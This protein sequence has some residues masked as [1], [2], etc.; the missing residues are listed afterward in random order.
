MRQADPSH[1]WCV[2]H[3][4]TR[5]DLGGAQLATLFEVEH[6]TFGSAPRY[7]LSGAGGLLDGETNQLSNVEHIVVSNLV[8]EIN[9]RRDLK[10]IFEI[11]GILRG[12]HKG[13]HLLVH[14]HSSKAGILGR[15]AAFFA[16][17]DL[18]VHSIHGFGHP[19]HGSKITRA[20][21][22]LAEYLT[23]RITDGFTADSLANIQ[24]AK[25]EHLL[26]RAPS[27][28][29]YC[30]IDVDAFTR[31]QH[32]RDTTL[33]SL[34]V[35]VDSQVVINI[36]CLKPQKNPVAYLQIAFLLNKSHPK[37]KFLLVGD[38]ELRSEL[39]D[40]IADMGLEETV[41]MLGWRR[42]ISDLL[43][44]SD[45]FVLTS[46][47]E[48]LPQ[49][50]F[51]AMAAGLPLVATAV[52]GTPEAITSGYNGYLFAPEDTVGMASAINLLLSDPEQRHKMGRHGLTQVDK[53]S[54]KNMLAKLEAFYAR[55]KK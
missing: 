53:F 6:S 18:I 2:V 9:L 3:I 48:G 35:P 39:E 37:A 10:A 44:A 45:V 21:M 23:A 55:L 20:F 22:W 7:L 8:R 41:L 14:T 31:P 36:S 24:Q 25:R 42:D 54:Q 26:G 27:Q 43:H 5:L 34:N 1:R 38:G 17:A 28:V 47:W 4:V 50:F 52:D 32:A 16:G 51:Q 40:L 46:L 19:H 49:T 15:I 11:V 12:L 30:G 13:K 33:R 29:V